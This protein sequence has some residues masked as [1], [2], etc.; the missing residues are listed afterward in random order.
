MKHAGKHIPLLVFALASTFFVGALYAYMSYR[1][2]TSIREAVAIRQDILQQKQ[3]VEQEKEITAAY[4]ATSADRARLTTFFVSDDATIS[5]IETLENL[6]DATG[7]VVTLSG[8][9]ADDM[10]GKDAG[11]IGNI[12]VTINIK[13][14]WTA[15]MRT[16]SLAEVLPYRTSIQSVRL[17]SSGTIPAAGAAKPIS[18][19]S[20]QF[21][22]DAALMHVITKK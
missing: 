15:V 18:Q 12:K 16:L 8:I 20:A 9:V 19:W 5:F 21:T 11:T 10:E 13:G 7:A 1:V 3:Y 2:E 14:S 4:Q 22:L 17:D 6:G